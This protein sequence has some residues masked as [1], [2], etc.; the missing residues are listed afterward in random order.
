MKVSMTKIFELDDKIA[1]IIIK[2]NQK[3]FETAMSCS[4]HP[5]EKEITPYVMFTRFVSYRIEYIPFGWVV[6]ENFEELVIRRFFT[7]EEEKIFT[8]EQLVDIAAKELDNWV[9]SLLTFKN[10]YQEIINISLE[11]DKNESFK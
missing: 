3:G 6:D 9:D 8:K 11:E 1:D 7:E 2:L 5:D 4:G 10:P